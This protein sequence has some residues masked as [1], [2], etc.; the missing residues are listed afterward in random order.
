MGELLSM[1]IKE[2]YEKSLSY[3]LADEIWGYKHPD[4]D[5]NSEDTIS[6]LQKREHP[7]FCVTAHSSAN[8]AKI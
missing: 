6:L 1:K 8:R 5:V 2:A 7:K 4:E 3:A